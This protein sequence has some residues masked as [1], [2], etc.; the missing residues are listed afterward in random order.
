MTDTKKNFNDKENPDTDIVENKSMKAMDEQQT[1]NQ[2]EETESKPA[3]S[4]DED[5]PADGLQSETPRKEESP[6]LKTIGKVR[7]LV[8]LTI[9]KLIDKIIPPYAPLIKL[10]EKLI[11]QEKKVDYALIRHYNEIQILVGLLIFILG[12]V[13]LSIDGF[14]FILIILGIILVFTGFEIE[15]IYITS[16]RLLIRRIGFVERIIRVP[17]DEEHL[18]SHVVSFNVGRAP[19]NKIL[20][21]LA[22]IVPFLMLFR[23]LGASGSIPQ[24]LIVILLIICAVILIIGMRLGRRILVIHLSGGHVVML[25]TRKGIP[26]HLLRS[27]MQ[28]VY[29]LGEVAES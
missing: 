14:L 20:T 24:I 2:I 25:G 5:K 6:L 4:L 3:K 23:E 11:P 13:L 22:I 15:E 12:F 27:L 18:L 10:E 29:Q 19:M 21:S 26:E 8:T 1:E 9:I 16:I 28:S 7:H 17:S